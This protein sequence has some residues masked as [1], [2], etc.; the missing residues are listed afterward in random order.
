MYS[1]FTSV[2]FYIIAF[3]VAMALVGVMFNPSKH[4]EAITYFANGCIKP[5]LSDGMPTL[6]SI[7]ED[8]RRLVLVHRCVAV[9]IG[10][11][12]SIA[13]VLSGSDMRVSEKFNIP[14]GIEPEEAEICDIIYTIDFLLAQRYHLYFESAA[15]GTYASM[16]V[17]NN[18][19]FRNKS[20]FKL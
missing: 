20:E 6:E 4:G 13:I 19:G 10:V 11:T 12:S 8:N 15:D 2:E 17:L 5:A 9:P 18:E 1:I 16:S 3:V 14:K 7:G